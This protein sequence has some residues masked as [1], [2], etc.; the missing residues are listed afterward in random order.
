[1]MN[2]RSY[3][4]SCFEAYLQA[5]ENKNDKD[6]KGKLE[7]Y[8][9]SID[10]SYQDFQI[11]CLNNELELLLPNSIY[12][13]VADALQDLYAYQSKIVRD[14]KKAIN[15]AQI[16]K[17]TTT[18][19]NCTINSVNTF[20][21]ILGQAKFPEFA[22][23][24]HNL[25][26]SCSECNGYKSSRFMNGA[27]RRFLNLYLDSLPREQY[28][29]ATVVPDGSSIDFSF[30][31]EN[32]NGIDADLF[33]VINNHYDSLHLLDRMKSKA[34]E[35]YVSELMTSIKTNRRNLSLS[36]IINDVI[37]NAH[38]NMLAYGYNHFKYILEVALVN[39]PDF[40]QLTS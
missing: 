22:I 1:M 28:L 19:Q 24:A 13:P 3:P 11:A 35:S 36:V 18:C 8:A 33:A 31:I 5:I 25:F 12:N 27:H 16:H 2:L 30:S 32:R 15:S 37:Q 9:T 20:D 40:I 17:I 29:F 4:G 38:L 21:H 6:L 14:I 7:T 39:S 23:N 10:A 26:P 34:A